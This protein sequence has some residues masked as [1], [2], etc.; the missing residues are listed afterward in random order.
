MSFDGPPVAD[1]E[2]I[3]L[4]SDMDSAIKLASSQMGSLL[5]RL[6]ADEKL[7]RTHL[8]DVEKL[9]LKLRNLMSRMNLKKGEGVLVKDNLIGYLERVSELSETYNFIV[10][11]IANQNPA[12]RNP[13][14]MTMGE[15]IQVLSQNVDD[16]SDYYKEVNQRFLELGKGLPLEEARIRCMRAF[17]KVLAAGDTGEKDFSVGYPE[18]TKQLI[19]KTTNFIDIGRYL[20]TEHDEKTRSETSA[21]E[22]DKLPINE[23]ALE[24]WDYMKARIKGKYGG[25]ASNPTL[26]DFDGDFSYNSLSGSVID[27]YVAHLK[28][29]FSDLDPEIFEQMIKF[30]QGTGPIKDVAYVAWLFKE[31]T[32]SHGTG[33]SKLHDQKFSDPLFVNAFVQAGAYSR[34]R[35]GNIIPNATSP[36]LILFTEKMAM[37]L[38]PELPGGVLNEEKRESAK[39]LW[40]MVNAFD[41]DIL[42]RGTPTFLADARKLFGIGSGEIDLYETIFPFTGEVVVDAYKIESK[43][44]H[45]VE[46]HD[47]IIKLLTDKRDDL[48][49][50][51]LPTANVDGRITVARANKK[52]ALEDF[53]AKYAKYGYGPGLEE[54]GIGRLTKDPEGKGGYGLSV[55]Q[56]DTSAKAIDEMREFFH[57]PL[58]KLSEKQCVDKWTYWMQSIVGKAKLIPGRHYLLFPYFTMLAAL[59]IVASFDYRNVSYKVDGLLEKMNSEL[60]QA[61]G[62]PGYVKKEVSKYMKQ[63]KKHFGVWELTY[64][65][66]AYIKK[67]YAYRTRVMEG[68]EEKMRRALPLSMG[69]VDED[70]APLGVEAPW[71]WS[72]KANKDT[73][74]K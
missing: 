25:I 42:W 58:G 31:T 36:D 62:I 4:A 40:K 17:Q 27:R 5:K 53:I 30:A 37:D 1:L 51:S 13:R 32:R 69:K 46:S 35:Y 15:V 66:D 59:K 70:G 22:V 49:G 60:N 61:G 29:V 74:E 11:A 56:Y 16:G 38:V 39:D 43:K 68:N 50:K 14:D 44:R 34:G 67:L 8:V 73:S 26:P 12:N 63:D 64:T 21:E 33:Y 2:S 54:V 6:D 19:N 28:Q 55:T 10:E 48:I 45:L 3:A 7:D 57:N 71:F 23:R 24:M 52:K 47:A 18:V 72:E 9:F 20:F 41:I 65:S